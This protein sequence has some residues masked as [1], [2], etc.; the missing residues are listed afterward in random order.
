MLHLTF[1]FFQEKH[2]K[3]QTILNF[4]LSSLGE[5]TMLHKTNQCIPG[6]L[7]CCSKFMRKYY[8]LICLAALK[9]NRFIFSCLPLR[10][11]PF[12]ALFSSPQS[13][14]GSKDCAYVNWIFGLFILI[15]KNITFIIMPL[16]T[17]R[18]LPMLWEVNMSNVCKN[19]FINNG[20]SL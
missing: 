9:H 17:K 15:L 10:L 11:P 3:K 1:F 7:S 12:L 6:L 18:W 8:P 4:G 14:Q 5:E 2:I 16:W 13:P 19:Q 20:Y